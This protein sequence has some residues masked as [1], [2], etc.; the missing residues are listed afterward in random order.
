[1][2]VYISG[3]ITGVEDHMDAFMRAEKM[4]IEQ[5]HEVINPA[6]VGKMLPESTKHEEYMLVSYA[7]M[8]LCEAVYFLS[9]WQ[10]SKGCNQEY[11]FA[12]GRGLPRFF[13]AKE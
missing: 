9:G 10:Q 11:G 5:G 4:L 13:E 3:A 12:V 2:K 1:M 7:L 8:E 6:K